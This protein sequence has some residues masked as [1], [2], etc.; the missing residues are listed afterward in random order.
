MQS[1]SNP[2]KYGLEGTD[3]NHI[4]AKGQNNADCDAT[5]GVTTNDAL[6]IQQYLLKQ[7]T[8]LPVK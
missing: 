7:V 3:K 6:V 8:K 1:L 2:N 4:T 5:K